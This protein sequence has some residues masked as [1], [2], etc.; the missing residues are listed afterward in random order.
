MI[1]KYSTQDVRERAVQA[2]LEGHA[3]TDVADLYRVH[4]ST[5]HRWMAR[6]E[7]GGSLEALAR[8]EGSG[9][10]PLLDDDAMD[11]VCE[12]ALQPASEYGYETD[13]WTCRRLIQVVEKEL[14]IHASQPTMWRML[15]ASGL[16]WQKPERRYKEASAAERRAWIRNEIPKILETVRK[17]KAILYFEDEANV[18]L[19][20]SLGKTW[21][22]AGQTPTQSVTGAR[23]GV[24]AMSAISRRGDLVFTL[25]EKRIASGEVVHFLDQM[26]KHHPRRH[27]VVVMDQARPH[28]SKATR[29]FIESQRRLHVFYLPPYSPDFNPDEKVWNHLKHFELKSHQAKTKKELKALTKRKLKN[30]SKQP[31]LMRGI[32]FRC[33][34]ANLL[35]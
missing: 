26:L 33:E 4:R 27:V 5:V 34:V 31:R 14:G 21:A 30:M 11:E 10:K 8:K 32:F 1:N 16:T 15:R 20:A 7:E 19:T 35:N 17:H 2:L 24:S 18:S 22:P 29:S 12:M 9:K 13:F 28:T 3:A 25:H 6:Y 23:G